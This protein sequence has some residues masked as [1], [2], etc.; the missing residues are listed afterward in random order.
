MYEREAARALDLTA[1]IIDETGPRLAGTEACKKGAAALAEAA[2]AV[3]DTVSTE[4]FTVHP[5]AFLG[6]IRLLVVFYA[7][8]VLCLA[9]L[10]SASAALS[11]AGVVVL[12]L[13]FFLYREAID[14]FFPAREG[15]NVIGALEPR[16][17]ALRQVIVS[18]HHDS[19]RIFNFYVDRPELFARR[20][21]SGIGTLALLALASTALATVPAP[22]A[23]RVALSAAFAL[24]FM[25]VAPLW[26]FA[27]REGTPGAG[28]NLASSAAAL[29]IAR[30]LRERRDTGEGLES[31]RIVF[32]S[33][34]AEEAGLRGARAFAKRRRAEFAAL[35]TFA[36]NMDCIYRADKLRFLLSDLNC[37]VKL[38]APVAELCR[39]L[40]AEE[41]IAATTM[42]IAFLTG[43]T[44]AAEL[45]KAGVRAASLIA[46]DW[47]GAARASAYHTPADTVDAVE[48]AALEA[49]IR[50]GLRFALAVEKGRLDRS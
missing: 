22:F 37:S 31:T 5:G 7:G 43:G 36:Y 24:G 40:A 29:E 21:N 14:P 38:D 2:G 11:W 25:L 4:R 6:F 28:D 17:K 19:A 34:D 45:A 42:P 41:G 49:A 26:N 20:I 13:E 18:G 1:R 32:A 50:I 44:D 8:A 33:F 16:G 47:S 27:S 3:C 30:L 46:M 9:F 39:E 48:P 15:L 23:L 12:V 35:P 10:P